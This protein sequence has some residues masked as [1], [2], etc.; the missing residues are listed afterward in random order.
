MQLP[1][2]FGEAIFDEIFILML[3][4]S[5][6]NGVVSCLWPSLKVQNHIFQYNKKTWIWILMKVWYQKINWF[7]KL[8]ELGWLSSKDS[9]IV[10][11]E[12][13]YIPTP[14]GERLAIFSLWSPAKFGNNQ[15]EWVL[16]R[17]TKLW[18]ELLQICKTYRLYFYTHR[19]VDINF[20]WS[21]R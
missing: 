17:N 16:L 20:L 9:E 7:E 11:V 1:D 13:G 18:C 3:V 10:E 4:N 6:K 5:H 12:D 14:M 2:V 19:H 8:Y 21:K 15:I